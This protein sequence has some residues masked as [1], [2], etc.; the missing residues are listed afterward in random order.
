MS[1]SAAN[2]PPSVPSDD[3]RV[4]DLR[5]EI[6]AA[7]TTILEL[8]DQ[9]VERETDRAD[10][11]AL[12]GQAELLLEEKIR[13]IMT[14]DHSLNARIR[15]LE[16]ECDRKTEEIDRRG[17][18]LQHAEAQKQHECR[19]R[20]RAI[21][22]LSAA[23][24]TANQE[25]TRAHELA[26]K[27][28]LQRADNETKLVEKF[29]EFAT[30]VETLTSTENELQDTRTKAD[31]LVQQLDE[32]RATHDQLEATLRDTQ[33]SL[34]STSTAKARMDDKLRQIKQSWLWRLARP[35]RALFGPD[36]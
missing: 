13:Y 28:D 32:L 29:R 24:E 36:L 18:A 17:S 7:E 16:Q 34:E 21:K 14:L 25:I 33:S 30:T 1:D 27:L 6:I 20:D 3:S 26:R 15:E 31:A 5:R 4:D 10:A 22:D 19:E 2:P 11:V 23:L 12:L 35:W 8:K 9:L